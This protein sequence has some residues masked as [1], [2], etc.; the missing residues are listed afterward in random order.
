MPNVNFNENVVLQGCLNHD[1]S[2]Q[3]LLY[4]RYKISM[5]TLCLRYATDRSDAEDIL[6]D[7]FLQIFKQLHQFD[8]SRGVLEA[9]MRKVV[10]NTALQQIRKKK[11]SFVE[12]NDA[13]P[14]LST[15]EDVV[16]NMSLKELLLHIRRLP[17][18]YRTVFNMYVIDGMQ[19]NEIAEMLNITVS[20]SKTQLFK[21]KQLLKKSITEAQNVHLGS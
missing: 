2:S 9:W 16:S 13:Q 19:H 21:A 1:P 12:M 14:Q 6:Q 20:T 10:I 8:S 5:F 3:K 11:M 17:T 7:G 18:G 15:D 4:E